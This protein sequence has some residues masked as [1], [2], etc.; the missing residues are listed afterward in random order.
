MALNA[1]TLTIDNAASASYALPTAANKLYALKNIGANVIWLLHAG[2]GTAAA[3]AAECEAIPAGAVIYT[4]G[5]SAYPGGPKIIIAIA[6][7][8]ATKLNV[9]TDMERW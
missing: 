7:T 4:Q 5:Y 6:A 9:V 2:T 8:G 3:E 1:A